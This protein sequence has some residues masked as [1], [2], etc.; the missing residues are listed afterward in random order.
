MSDVHGSEHLAA[1]R[2]ALVKAFRGLAS[3]WP[4]FFAPSRVDEL[5]P[6]WLRA[7]AGIDVAVLEPAALEFAASQSGKYAP[8]PNAFAAFA[9]SMERRVLGD[10]TPRVTEEPRSIF[11]GAR[12]F[13]YAK[14]G[15]DVGYGRLDAEN[16]IGFA[17]V[18]G[19]SLNISEYEMDKIL[20]HEID[21][22]WID[23]HDVPRMAAPDA[24]FEG[25]VEFRAA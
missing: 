22:A 19:G 2:A 8:E 4:K 12:A 11:S 14:P 20:G 23:P 9:R 6:V 21:W 10:H 25:R 24:F 13:R 16:A 1:R 5:I 17:I 3:R 18:S 15:P 7:V